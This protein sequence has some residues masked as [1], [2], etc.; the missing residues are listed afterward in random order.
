[1]Y[2]FIQSVDSLLLQKPRPIK[3]IPKASHKISFYASLVQFMVLQSGSSPFHSFCKTTFQ[4][5]VMLSEQ[6]VWT[7]CIL[8]Y[9]Y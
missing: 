1:M 7:P 8:R 3:V 5:N 6:C 4:L 9:W 2:L